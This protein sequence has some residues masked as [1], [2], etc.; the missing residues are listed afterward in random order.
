MTT[1]CPRLIV[2]RVA[3]ARSSIPASGRLHQTGILMISLNASTA[4]FL[5]VTTI[6][7]AS[8]ASLLAIM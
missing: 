3:R 1:F 6:W 8:D 4:L 5:I 7:V 2:E